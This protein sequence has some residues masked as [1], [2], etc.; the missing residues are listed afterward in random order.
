[1]GSLFILFH[2]ILFLPRPLQRLLLLCV[3]VCVC[4][5]VFPL[6]AISMAV[7][8]LANFL[9]VVVGVSFWGQQAH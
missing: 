7:A 9:Y 3:C 1:M 2:F 4:M 5:C 6:K 8:F